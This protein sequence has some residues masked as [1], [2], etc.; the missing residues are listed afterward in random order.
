[1]IGNERARENRANCSAIRSER[2]MWMYGCACT[3]GVWSNGNDEYRARVV[4]TLSRWKVGHDSGN[5]IVA[6][7]SRRGYGV[8]VGFSF[9]RLLVEKQYTS[10]RG[11]WCLDKA[12]TPCR[13]ATRT[14]V[15]QVPAVL[16]AALVSEFLGD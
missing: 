15:L 12:K 1:M 5:W 11:R 16:L 14:Q 9:F 3:G 7:L 6:W 8:E 2:C 10:G 4:R 13:S